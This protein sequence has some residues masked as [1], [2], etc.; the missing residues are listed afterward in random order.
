MK[1]NSS[2]EFL[3]V[4]SLTDLR[5]LS[6]VDGYPNS[7]TKYL[8]DNEYKTYS[9][10]LKS[11]DIQQKINVCI[12][13]REYINQDIKDAWVFGL[14][15]G[16]TELET[17]E[18]FKTIEEF[19]YFIKN[20][21]N[22]YKNLK[23]TLKINEDA[24]LKSD[25]TD[26]VTETI[27]TYDTVKQ[28]VDEVNDYVRSMLNKTTDNKIQLNS[29]NL[30]E[31]AV[32]FHNTFDNEELNIVETIQEMLASKEYVLSDDFKK[33]KLDLK[34][35]QFK[36]KMLTSPETISKDEILAEVFNIDNTVSLI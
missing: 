18:V 28:C 29:Y 16:I 12:L 17:Y 10:E 9:F 26:K 1:H 27:N 23:L 11:F 19:D 20:D 3:V 21:F 5:T 15:R 24:L 4:H 2:N 13:S 25:K 31:K 35:I 14:K 8:L 34:D 33:N 7:H 6:S 32:E 36:F 22:T 30:L